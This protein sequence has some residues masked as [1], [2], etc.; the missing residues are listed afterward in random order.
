[1]H[2]GRRQR[3]TDGGQTSVPWRL[4]RSV[5]DSGGRPAASSPR[6]IGAAESCAAGA[7]GRSQIIRFRAFC[8]DPGMRANASLAP[9]RLTAVGCLAAGVA[10]LRPCRAQCRD[11]CAAC[12]IQLRED[13]CR[14][15]LEREHQLPGDL[16]AGEVGRDELGDLE[17]CHPRISGPRESVT[18]DR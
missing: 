8:T 11:L 1:M 10:A 14:D 17:P 18:L 2:A 5:I 13:V 12:S 6:R 16:P 3:V 4:S 15:F 9:R 7:G